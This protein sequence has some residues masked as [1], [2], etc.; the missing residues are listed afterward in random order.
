V[1]LLGLQEAIPLL[2]DVSPYRE[3]HNQ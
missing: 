3:I 2:V 1:I